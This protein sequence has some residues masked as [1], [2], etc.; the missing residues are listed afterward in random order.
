MADDANA[1]QYHLKLDG[2]KA[3][4]ID[5]YVEYH[6]IVGDDDGGQTFTPEEYEEYKK[7]VLPIRLKNRLYTSYSSPSGMDCKLIGPETPCFCKHRYKEHK[8]DFEVIPPERPVH[9]PCRAKGCRCAAFH[10][11]PMNGG[12]PIRCTCKHFTDDHSEVKPYS[13]FTCAC[14]AGH[15]QHIMIIETA[16]EREARGHPVGQAVPYAAMGGITGFSSLAEG[17]QRLDPSG[18]GAPSEEWL[19]Q[20]ITS[21]DNPFLRANVQSIK[22]HQIAKKQAGHLTGPDDEVF[23]D[24]AERVSAM[25]RPGESDMDYFERRYQERLKAEKAASKA[26]PAGMSGTFRTGQRKS[27]EPAAKSSSKRPSKN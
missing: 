10:F 16:E 8:T 21:S 20:P 5:A 13:S 23:D 15:D 19:N 24:M 1:R 6:R 22:A 17:Y 26:G 14:G 11:V 2:S 18:R 25:R 12:Q 3:A 7:K 4:A 27:I 9:L